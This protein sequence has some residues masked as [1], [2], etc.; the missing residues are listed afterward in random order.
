[1][2]ILKT[3]YFLVSKGALTFRVDP[4]VL[5][6]TF[7]PETPYG[8]FFMIGRNFRAFQVRYRDIARGGVRVVMPRTQADFDNALA[9]LFDEV[10]GLAYAQQLKNKD[11]P[12][13]GSK[14]V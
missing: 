5:N 13:G 11:I 1:H 6:K 12:E 14:C 7:Y 2:N 9:G 8:I 3:N 4:R 10:N